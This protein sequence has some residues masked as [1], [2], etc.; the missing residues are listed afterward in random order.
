[1]ARVTIYVPK[2]LMDRIKRDRAE[3]IK[4]NL[5]SVSVEAIRKAIDAPLPKP[6]PTPRWGWE[7][8]VVGIRTTDARTEVVED[9]QLEKCLNRLGPE[10]EV[11]RMDPLTGTSYRVF[12]RKSVRLKNPSESGV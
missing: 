6:E 4:H 7:Y 11:F 3:G 9:I 5:S 2:D 1:M 10:W 8:K 12:A